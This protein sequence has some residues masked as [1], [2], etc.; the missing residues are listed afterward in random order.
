MNDRRRLLVAVAVGVA[1][2]YVALTGLA[3]LW[4]D[5]MWFDSVGFVDVWRIRLVA[6]IGLAVAGFVIVFGFIFGNLVLTDRLSPRYTL[7]SQDDD[8]ELVERFRD[9]VEPRLRLVRLGVSAAFALL[10]GVGAFESEV[11][12]DLPDRRRPGGV[13]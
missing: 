12:P 4:T 13:A 8:E 5:Y 3:T 6:S 11:V 9:W 7:F 1:V 10:I 2:A